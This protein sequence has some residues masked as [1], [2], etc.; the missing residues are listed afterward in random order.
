MLNYITRVSLT[1]YQIFQQLSRDNL[2]SDSLP[3]TVSILGEHSSPMNGLHFEASGDPSTVAGASVLASFS[4][5][6][7][8]FSLLPPPSCDD[9][10][11]QPELPTLPFD[12]EVSDN[13]IVDAD[14]KDAA[15][16]NDGTSASVN[17]KAVASTNADNENINFNSSGHDDALDAE[18]EKV[19]ETTPELRP[20]LRMLS[21]TS[22]P[23]FDLSNSISK[24]LDQQKVLRDGPKDMDGTML[25]SKRRQS[26]KEGLQQRIL[27]SENIEVSIESFPYYLRCKLYLDFWHALL[28]EM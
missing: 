8:E 25:M 9:E 28:F 18:I 3:P 27:R 26:F 2:A 22:A 5:L 15:D 21:G 14:L 1:D 20:L 23:E 4:N 19:P 13:H 10:D 24:I 17:E 11:V 12:C 16:Q 7:N 6:R